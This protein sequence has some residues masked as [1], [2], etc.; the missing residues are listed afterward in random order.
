MSQQ[1]ARITTQKDGAVLTVRDD[2]ERIDIPLSFGL[3]LLLLDDL[4]KAI[5]ELGRDRR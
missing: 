3:A 4:A 2:G 1:S 5:L